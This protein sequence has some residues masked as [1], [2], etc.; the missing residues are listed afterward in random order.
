MNTDLLRRLCEMPGVPG[1]EERVRDLILAEIKDLF[2][3]VETDPMG[4]LLCRREGPRKTRP[5]SCCSA[6]WT[7]SAFWSANLDKGLS[8]SN[9]RRL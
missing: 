3:H 5:R 9:R 6:T 8:S 4:S 7:R 1:H 2:D